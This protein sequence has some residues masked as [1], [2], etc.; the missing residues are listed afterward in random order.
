MMAMNRVLLW[1]AD[2]GY[3]MLYVVTLFLLT[4]KYT[5]NDALSGSWYCVL[6]ILC[7]DKITSADLICRFV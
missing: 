4:G 1:M 3:L 2:P 5:N 6:R 7:T